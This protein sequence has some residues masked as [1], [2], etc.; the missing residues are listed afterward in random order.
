[1][2]N[3]L[4]RRFPAQQLP[5]SQKGKKW[6]KECVD[7]AADHSFL[8]DS[9]IRQS[10][11]HKTINYNLVNGKLFMPDVEAVLNPTGL[12]EKF[13]PSTIQH[14]PIINS[15]LH[16]LRGEEYK[17]VFDYKVVVTNPNSLSEIE[18]NK[19]T[20]LLTELQKIIED[21]SSD[22]TEFQRKLEDLNQYY[23]YEWQDF[24]EIRANALVNHY[25][26]EQ[27]FALMFND[28]FMDALTVGEE[29]YC[30][31][32]V[33]GEPVVERLNPLN[34]TVSKSGMSNK[35]EDADMIVIEE[36]WSPGRIIDT[37][38]DELTASDRKEI[39]GMVSPTYDGDWADELE[40]YAHRD[41]GYENLSEQDKI[42]FLFGSSANYRGLTPF[43][44]NGNV[45]VVRVFW[46][47]RRKI[48][49][50]KS[51]DPKTGEEDYDFRSENY[52]CDKAKGETEEIL[53][54]NEAWEGTKIGKDIYVNIR[55]RVVQ[56]N[57][58]SNPSRCHFGIVGTIYNI[59]NNE[60]FSMV[61]MM[62]RYSY[63][64]DVIFDRLNRLLAKNYGK[65]TDLDLSKV[66][67]GWDVE[68]WLYYARRD[69]L[70][71]TNSFNEGK[72]GMAT[73]KLAGNMNN[74]SRGVIDADQGNSIQQY[75]NLL[76]FINLSM[77]EA[78]GISKQ[79]EGQIS[80]RETVGGVERATLQSS[81]ITEWLFAK[82]DDTKKR[83]TEC[84]LETSKIS[85]K[86]KNKKFPYIL[87]DY[88]QR[89][90][91][92]SGDEF[93]ESDYGLIVDNSQ[94]AQEL[95]Q[96][97]D[98]LAQAAIQN[99]KTDFSTAMKLY[100]SCS[101][102]EK[103]R[104]I[105]AGEQQVIQREQ[106]IREQE[107]QSQQ[108]IAQM[109]AQIKM[110]EMQLKDSINQRDNETKIEIALIQAGSDKDVQGLSLEELSLKKQDLLLKMKALDEQIKLDARKQEH[111]EKTAKDKLNFDKTKLER[112]LALKREQAKHK[113]QQ[114]Q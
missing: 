6:R 87:P 92:I 94:H 29:I 71:V 38:Y 84:F 97:L 5:M 72:Q 10:V 4:T 16:I 108:Q 98:A 65:L 109:E 82:H 67:N 57:R 104:L 7:A 66:P 47:S 106:Q 51:F 88:A 101:L 91:D 36:Y 25:S 77:A 44:M 86:G 31:D 53:W 107:A 113:T 13:V 27:N 1:M 60:P 9:A 48:K 52:V 78:V 69:N 58:L 83:V 41:L 61:D 49:K 19:K 64:Y 24:R 26:R 75:V 110:Q 17:R 14:Y 62:K 32:I 93:S 43:D 2:E 100:G 3:V 40:S 95:D 70:Y 76:Q 45:R 112:E 23:S 74:A 99:G 85:L 39:E 79:R 81:H 114:K 22:E 56:Y 73:G 12:P 35:I 34:V 15:K 111:Q 54:I 96:K 102:A 103:Q 37:Y 80:N 59:N 46:K 42:S 89:I 18:D 21:T 105:A 55:P 8:T 50:V 20:E 11:I 30:C 90:A 28:G 33:G 68:K 63:L